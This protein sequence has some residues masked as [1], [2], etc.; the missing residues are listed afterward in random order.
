MSAPFVMRFPTPSPQVPGGIERAARALAERVSIKTRVTLVVTLFF[1]LSLTLITTVQFYHAKESITTVLAEQQHTFVVQAADDLDYKLLDHLHLLAAATK[2]LS[3]EML[4]NTGALDAWVSQR[5]GLQSAFDDLFVV[6]A[7]GQVLVDAQSPERRGISMMD[8]DT[9]QAALAAR[10]P[11]ISKPT[12][13]RRSGQPLVTFWSPVL[14][15]RGELQALVVGVLNLLKP[16]FLG[17][18]AE[19]KVGKTGSFAVFTRDRTIVIS[20]DKSRIL[21]TGPAP[22]VSPYFDHATAGGEGSEEAVNS[23]GLHAIFSYSQL[24]AVPWVL[25]AALPVAEAYAPI[26]QARRHILEVTLLL[27]LL[28][29]PLVW[30]AVRRLYDPLRAS[31]REREAGLQRAQAMAK[32]SHVVTGPDGGFESWST[33]LSKLLGVAPDAMPKSIREWQNHL[34]PEDRAQFR[35]NSIT[36]ARS[37]QRLDQHYRLCRPD[38][39]VIEV[40]QAMEPI[41]RPGLDGKSRWFNTLQDVTEQKQAEAKIKRLNRVHAMFSGIT[42]LI[43]RAHQREELFHEACRVA[44]EQGQFKA[45]AIGVVDSQAQKLNKLASAGLE[46]GFLSAFKDGFP[47]EDDSPLRDTL[48]ARVVRTRQPLVSNDVQNDPKSAF[49]KACTASGIFF[50]AV[51]PLMVSSEVV[52][53]FSLLAGETDFFDSEEVQ[54]LVNLAAD[55]S[56]ALEHLAKADR[57]DYLVYHDALTGL[58]NRALFLRRLDERLATARNAAGRLSVTVLDIEQLQSVN[59]AFGRQVGDQLLLQVADR[60]TRLRG[61][62]LRLARIGSESFAVVSDDVQ[63]EGEVSRLTEHKLTTCFGP[64]FRV[65]EQELTI[66]AKAGIAMYPND[67]ESAETLLRCAESALKRVKDSGDRHMFFE[68]KMTERVAERLAMENELRLAVERQEFVL[69]YQPKVELDGL[70]IVGVEALIRWNNPKRG[71]VPPIEFIPLLEENG[72][73]LQV[74]AWALRRAALDHRQWVEQGL[75]APRVGVNV[76]A[77]QL[78]QKDF[79]DTVKRAVGEGLTPTGI[80]LE[81]TESLLMDDVA[82]GVAKLKELREFGMGVALDDF[83]TGYS[84]LAYVAKLPLETLKID[85]SFVTAMDKDADTMTL[86]RTIISM[87]HALRLKVIA[88]GVETQAQA[89]TLAQLHCEQMQGYLFSKPVPAEALMVMLPQVCAK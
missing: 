36:A 34:H 67:G 83:G 88:E 73:I 77:I 53:V 43:V 81:V 69:H 65:G 23:R 74:G 48:V 50:A 27:A 5:Q 55:I 72:L 35:A 38:G 49:A 16:N 63:G 58:A 45:A 64:P 60:L 75:D 21:T 31:L 12:L 22:G 1:L 14:D 13:G 70:R 20:R 29:A 89:Q 47:L 26:Q 28:A 85:R 80:D 3:P 66:P 9:F 41:G 78:R 39:S 11:S 33:T 54:L 46:P 10:K 2:T 86:V 40:L 7:M 57:L 15:Q 8:R 18:L 6:S 25:V 71:L 17:D 76:S 19:A 61:D 42:T 79:V 87:A 84:S 37:R 44:V 4:K 68:P 82:G 32:L 59:N 52:G 51:L 62:P 56:F 30:L 24:K